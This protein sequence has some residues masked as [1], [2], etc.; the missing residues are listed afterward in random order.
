[1]KLCN[2]KGI[3][4]EAPKGVAREIFKS[5]AEE[6]PKENIKASSIETVTAIPQNTNEE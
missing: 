2:S 5:L 4:E 6:I 1:M 3:T